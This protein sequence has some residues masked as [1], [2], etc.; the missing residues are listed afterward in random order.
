MKRTFAVLASIFV[1]GSG[2]IAACGGPEKTAEQKVKTARTDQYNL[3]ADEL[4][5]ANGYARQ[6]FEKTF[7]TGNPERPKVDGTFLTCKG[8]DGGSTSN[9][10]QLVGCTCTMPDIETGELKMKT[11]YCR[12]LKDGAIGCQETDDVVQ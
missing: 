11:V 3:T 12:Y 8:T 4:N 6:Y 9:I 2:L 7:K 10:N 1:L 5:R